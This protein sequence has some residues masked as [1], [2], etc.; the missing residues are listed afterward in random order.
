M[1]VIGVRVEGNINATVLLKVLLAAH[2]AN[3]N[4]TVA[5]QAIPLEQLDDT[6]VRD[7]PAACQKCQP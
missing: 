7:A 4:Q 1:A 6:S 3:E 5:R 2:P